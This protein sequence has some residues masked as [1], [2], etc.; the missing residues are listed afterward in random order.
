MERV[1]AVAL[2]P[3]FAHPD[4]ADHPTDFRGNSVAGR[5]VQPGER[6]TVSSAPDRWRDHYGAYLTRVDTEMISTPVRE[7]MADSPAPAM[8]TVRAPKLK[9]TR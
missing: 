2:H 1:A 3:V 6:L 8:A 4:W 7:Q 5:W 9:K